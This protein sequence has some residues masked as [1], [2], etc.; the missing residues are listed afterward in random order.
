[1]RLPKILGPEDD[2]CDY[3]HL[4]V[5]EYQVGNSTNK[6]NPSSQIVISAPKNSL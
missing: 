2:I 3:A 6:C 4:L 1:M 5:Q